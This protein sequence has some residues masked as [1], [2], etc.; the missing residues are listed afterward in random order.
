MYF[1][2]IVDL[3]GR[4]DD[5]VSLGFML[6]HFLRG[7]LPWEDLKTETNQEK[8]RIIKMKSSTGGLCEG[9]PGGPLFKRILTFLSLA[10]YFAQYFA[11]CV[12][13][14]LVVTSFA[15]ALILLPL[16]CVEEFAMYLRACWHMDN[17]DAPNYAALR[18]L[19]RNV[20]LRQEGIAH[21]NSYDWAGR[22]TPF[23]PT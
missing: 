6:M 16:E 7:N 11:R 5:M 12:F 15:L 22:S 13:N 8:E 1:P 9:F 18:R 14:S 10:V 3:Q 4:R 21:D 2:F 19:F 17:S 23:W 20:Y